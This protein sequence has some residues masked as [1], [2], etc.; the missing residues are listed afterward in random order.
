MLRWFNH[1]VVIDCPGDCRYCANAEVRAAR[2][3]QRLNGLERICLESMFELGDQAEAGAI[4]TR[5]QQR[6]SKWKLPRI[7]RC[8]DRLE[9]RKLAFSRTAPRKINPVSGAKRLFRLEPLALQALGKAAPDESFDQQN[10]QTLVRVLC[11][12]DPLAPQE[13]FFIAIGICFEAAYAHR[14]GIAHGDIVPKTYSSRR[15]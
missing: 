2:K 3:A 15:I 7:Y 5:V 1:L 4:V 9:R 8:F 13:I 11:S 12:R 6:Q 10:A 14:Q